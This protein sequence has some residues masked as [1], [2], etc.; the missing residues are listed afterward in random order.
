MPVKSYWEKLRDPRWQK[1]RLEVMN[2]DDFSCVRCSAKDKTL[3]VHHLFY[4]RVSDPWEYDLDVL[5]TLCD[6]CHKLE[7]EAKKKFCKMIGPYGFWGLM[8]SV[9]TVT[10]LER[11][12]FSELVQT[13]LWNFSFQRDAGFASCM[14]C[15]RQL[16]SPGHANVGGHENGFRRTYH[17]SS[18]HTRFHTLEKRG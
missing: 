12:N 9:D 4:D 3:N 1:K 7:E 15:G 11:D 14:K 10:W 5:H 18:C 6:E 17:C 2:R 16:T 8:D 13:A